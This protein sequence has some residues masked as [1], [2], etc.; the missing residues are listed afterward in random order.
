MRRAHHVI[1]LTALAAASLTLTGCEKPAPGVTV[2]TG[3]QSV[4]SEALCWAFDADQLSPGTCAADILQGQTTSGVQRLTATPGNVVGVSVDP[5]VAEAGWNIVIG[6][7]KLSESPMT[8]TYFRFSLPDLPGQLGTEPV[9][10]QVV[11][12]QDTKIR[13]VWIVALQPNGV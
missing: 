2:F 1:G 9:P 5:A 3:T 11:A 10:L 8:E 6:G 13:G 12:G 7:Q 4:H